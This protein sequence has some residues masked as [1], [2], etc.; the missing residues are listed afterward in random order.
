VLFAT[1]ADVSPPRFVLF[2]TGALDPAYVRFI[3]RKLRE[4]FGFE[5]SPIEI[6]VKPRQRRGR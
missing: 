4:E 3:E 1:Q 2:T 6:V 5:G